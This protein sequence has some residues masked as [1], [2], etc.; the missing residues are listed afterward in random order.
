MN[1]E[2][3]VVAQKII[4]EDIEYYVPIDVAEGIYSEKNNTFTAHNITLKHIVTGEEFGYALRDN[5]TELIN[6][7]KYIPKVISKKLI[8]NILRKT[9]YIRICDDDNIPPYILQCNTEKKALVED[10][11]IKYYIQYFPESVEYKKDPEEEKININMDINKIYSEIKKK[12]LSQD[13]QIKEILSII[14]RDFNN[15]QNIK[16]RSIL[17]NGE[18]SS[19][20]REIFNIIEENINI[21]VLNTSIINRYKN[22][23]T[24]NS[25]QDILTNLLKKCNYDV[26]K[27]ETS[28]IV[29]DDIDTI[30]ILNENDARL[31]GEYQTD[32]LRLINGI[33][34]TIEINGDNYTINTSKMLIILM[35]DFVKYE[36]ELPVIKGFYDSHINENKN[37]N[38]IDYLNQGL[39]EDLVY[40]IQN[41]IELDK[42]LLEEY[43]NSIKSDKENSL[44]T[45]KEFLEKLNIKLTI[46]DKV[47]TRISEMVKENGYTDGG[48]DEIIDKA[49]A[50]A[51]FEIAINPNIYEELII[52]EN[53]IIDNKNYKLVKRK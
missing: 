29:I 16:S 17:I 18:K 6:K 23:N 49:L 52:D 31:F 38:R 24:L 37:M 22:N 3:A 35:G 40:S 8:L 43:I 10:D 44:N 34:F 30:T 42:P 20:K 47:I 41:I 50:L 33:P 26:K 7:Y 2:Y 53:T 45:T 51:S 28:I 27:A 13:N 11:I 25:I 15:Y 32:L 12:V 36:E 21:P 1:K 9:S 5:V 19:P 4:H 14:W 48:I 39:I 46:D